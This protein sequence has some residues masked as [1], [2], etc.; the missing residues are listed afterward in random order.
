[1]VGIAIMLKECVGLGLASPPGLSGFQGARPKPSPVVRLFSFTLNKDEVAIDVEIDGQ[2]LRT[3]DVSGTPWQAD[4]IA[5]PTEP[6][7]IFESGLVEVPLVKLAWGRSGDKGDKANVGI[8]CRD[9]LY[10]PYVWSALT[11]AVIAERFEHFLPANGSGNVERY[12]MP[13]SYAINILM[14]DVLGGG[15]MASIRNDAQGKGYAQLLLAC[16]IPVSPDIAKRVS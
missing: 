16:P 2:R 8:I 10:L 6:E 5:R 14:H 12:L 7:P 4:T 13:G 15:G 9:P 3:N 1:M 11:K